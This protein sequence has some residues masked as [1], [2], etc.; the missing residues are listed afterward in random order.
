[1]DKIKEFFKNPMYV[2]VIALVVGIVI[3][4]VG[5]GWGLW[6]VQWTDAAPIGFAG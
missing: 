5:L 4:L 3:G 1:M 6:P 2:G